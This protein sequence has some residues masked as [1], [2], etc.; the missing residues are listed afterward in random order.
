MS[1]FHA[2]SKVITSKFDVSRIDAKHTTSWYWRSSHT[3]R[4][5][6]LFARCGTIRNDKACATRKAEFKKETYKG[7]AHARLI[8][9]YQL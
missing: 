7:D 8:C 5:P 1:P 4:G 2:I 3:L 9:E 6:Y